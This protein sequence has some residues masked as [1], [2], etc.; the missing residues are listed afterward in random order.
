M[1][2]K[3]LKDCHEFICS[4]LGNEQSKLTITELPTD[5]FPTYIEILRSHFGQLRQ[6]DNRPQTEKIN[7]SH[8]P[9]SL[10]ECQDVILNPISYCPTAE[11]IIPFIVE[12]Q[13]V[14]QFGFH[15]SKGEALFVSG[16]WNIDDG[17]AQRETW[18]ELDATVEDALIFT[19]L[20]NLCLMCAEDEDWNFDED[21]RASDEPECAL[22][23]DHDAWEEF[24]GF[25]TNSD[26][27]LIHYSQNFLTVKKRE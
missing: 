3:N 23:W 15:P 12:N 22:L 9:R 10:L 7:R 16:D 11:G 25:W 2:I 21:T 4:W 17:N 20:G 24:D 6:N 8:T 14:W 27:T 19:L 18:K 26:R 5:N 13:G 1:I